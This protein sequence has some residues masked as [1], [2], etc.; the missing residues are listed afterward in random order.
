MNQA[1]VQ[2]VLEK[3]LE[4]YEGLALDMDQVAEVLNVSRKTADKL[5]L[6]L[7]AFPLDPTKER[8]DY[9]VTKANIIAYLLNKN[10][11]KGACNE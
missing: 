9:R 3:Q 5:K 11:L 8:K 1:E 10:N 4:K 6:E 2:A 7:K